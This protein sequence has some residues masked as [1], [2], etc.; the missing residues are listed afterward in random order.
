MDL[1]PYLSFIEEAE[2]LKSVVRT[3]WTST[4]RRESTAEHSWRL[5]LLAVSLSDF[6]P[7]A[8]LKKVLI[9]CL[10]HDLGELYEGDISAALMPD[11]KE[12]YDS[13][14]KA[15]HEV[16]SLLPDKKSAELLAVWQEYNANET[17]EARLVKALDKAETIIQ[18]NQ[19]KN[20]ADFDYDFNLG[21]GKEYFGENEVLAEL[22]SLID[23][24]TK[25]RGD[26]E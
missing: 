16:F 22:R 2:Q 17:D 11:Q 14:Y 6:F 18:H 21:Y 19:G 20:P 12:K 13:E 1:K 23:E 24:K 15:V 10:V 3:A 9:M 8:D 26:R 25:L 4:G 7:D 5:A